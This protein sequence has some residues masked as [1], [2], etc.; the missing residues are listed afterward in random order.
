VSAS[1]VV[2]SGWMEKSMVVSVAGQGHFLINGILTCV[3]AGHRRTLVRE[4]GERKKSIKLINDN[5]EQN[6]RRREVITQRYSMVKLPH[7][8]PGY[9]ELNSLVKG[10]DKGG[11]K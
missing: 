2:A 10:R 5:L 7:A 9:T 6:N 3:I 11:R 8:E 4:V 1:R